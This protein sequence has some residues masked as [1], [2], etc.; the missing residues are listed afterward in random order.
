MVSMVSAHDLLLRLHRLKR[1]D[2]LLGLAKEEETDEEDVNDAGYIIKRR[3]FNV[4]K[5]GNA[6]ERTNEEFTVLE[7][8]KTHRYFNKA[9]CTALKHGKISHIVVK[10]DQPEELQYAFYDMEM[11]PRQPPPLNCEDWYYGS[12]KDFLAQNKQKAFVEWKTKSRGSISL[13]G[14]RV[15]RQ[16]EDGLFYWGQIVRFGKGKKPFEVFFDDGDTHYFSI[17]QI[18]SMLR[19][20]LPIT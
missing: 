11:Y 18:L 3:H 17:N 8:Y 19:V 12:C 4:S 20:Q 5:Y 7:R 16:F 1:L 9:N 13:V 2:L 10:A 14:K 6:A 15:C